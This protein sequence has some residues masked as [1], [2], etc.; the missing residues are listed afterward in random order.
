MLFRSRL[1]RELLDDNPDNV[2]I[3]NNF[4]Y[5][6]ADQGRKLDEAE[7]MIRR[8]IVLDRDA[9]IKA[10]DPD[11]ESGNYSDSL[12]WVLFKKGK[13]A[14]ARKALEAATQFAEVSENGVVWDHLG[15]TYFRLDLKKEAVAAYA[16]ALKLFTGSHEGKQFGRL[17]EVKRKLKLAE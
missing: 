15:D 13:F 9:R 14:E 16:K 10:G 6:L 2:L 12:G 8:A 4:G 3:L 11:A 17:D 5:Q 1:L 7:A